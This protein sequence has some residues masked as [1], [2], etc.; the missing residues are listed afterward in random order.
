MP[1]LTLYD[2][3]VCK[4]T[5]FA[6]TALQK[7]SWALDEPDA[8]KHFT[9]AMPPH[10]KHAVTRG[11]TPTCQAAAALWEAAKTRQTKSKTN[12]NANSPPLHK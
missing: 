3:N 9:K 5:D 1:R 2:N 12:N 6:C 7:E 10:I 8:S 11:T 4:V